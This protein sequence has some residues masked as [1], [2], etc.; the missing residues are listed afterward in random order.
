MSVILHNLL[1]N[2]SLGSKLTAEHLLREQDTPNLYTRFFQLT[3]KNQLILFFLI[4]GVYWIISTSVLQINHLIFI[5]VVPIIMAAFLLKNES[6]MKIFDDNQDDKIEILNQMMFDDSSRFQ[7]IYD[8]Q[9]FLTTVIDKKSYLYLQPEIVEFYFNHR[10]FANYNFA[11]YKRSLHFM[12]RYI[13]TLIAIQ[14]D[15]IHYKQIRYIYDE[16]VEFRKHCLNAWSNIIF[17][18][19]DRDRYL[20]DLHTKSMPIL[21][22]YLADMDERYVTRMELVW[23]LEGAPIT[24]DYLPDTMIRSEQLVGAYDKASNGDNVP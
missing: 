9:Y 13:S 22:R 5:I 24:Q 6:E 3:P 12:N 15:K 21:Q 4:C 14:S 18:L 10:E 8:K 19:E 16:A 11:E 23:K 17:G 2:L 20:Q 7:G 1:H